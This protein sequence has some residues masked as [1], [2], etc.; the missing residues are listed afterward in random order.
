MNDSLVDFALKRLQQKL[1][2][3]LA[4]AEYQV[5]RSRTGSVSVLLTCTWM[6]RK[7]HFFNCFFFK[8]LLTDDHGSA[9]SRKC[10]SDAHAA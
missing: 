1:A 2:E 4:P 8:K 6:Q 5:R 3:T 7:F 9:S 10:E